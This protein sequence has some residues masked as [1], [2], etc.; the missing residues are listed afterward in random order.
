MIV[1]FR[2]HS[3]LLN[4][5]FNI[6]QQR[7]DF[8]QLSCRNSDLYDV[9]YYAYNSRYISGGYHTTWTIEFIN[10][11]DFVKFVLLNK[12]RYNTGH[13][14]NIKELFWIYS[15]LNVKSPNNDG[16]YITCYGGTFFDDMQSFNFHI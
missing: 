5:P 7:I 9:K 10:S 4:S 8:G 2:S 11:S 13:K 15:Y 14:I 1:L 6:H 16:E 12:P 3:E